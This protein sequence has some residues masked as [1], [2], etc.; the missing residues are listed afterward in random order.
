VQVLAGPLLALVW[1]VAA[2]TQP[3][4]ASVG[5]SCESWFRQ[6]WD[7]ARTVPP[8]RGI[9]VTWREEHWTVPPAEELEALRVA[10]AERPEHPERGLVE[11]YDRHRQGQPTVLRY[12]LWV[13]P[14]DGWRFNTD[15]G[16]G[17]EDVIRTPSSAWNLN[18]G[19]VSLFDAARIPRGA[20]AAAYGRV[21][22]PQLGLLFF[23]GLTYGD[24]SG[25]AVSRFA[26]EG[27][28]WHA[29]A[30]RPPPGQVGAHHALRFDGSWDQASATGRVELVTL[31]ASDHA[32][33]AVGTTWRSSG[34][35]VD[36]MTG[37]R[38][39]ARVE[40]RSPAGALER[41]LVLETINPI[42]KGGFAALVNPPLDGRSDAV[43][44]SMPGLRVQEHR[45][46]EILNYEAGRRPGLI[47]SRA[48][49]RYAGWLALAAMLAGCAVAWRHRHRAVA[50]R[51][52]HG[53][54]R[55][56]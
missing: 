55:H 8:V 37:V 35:T 56:G 9:G 50:R 44:G 4:A 16:H 49:L 5:S 20:D 46:G 51:L 11:Q 54:H 53:G 21:F 45:D 43:R 41:V 48:I 39:A 27:E 10:V 14:V 19:Q 13:G 38:H 26:C 29:I 2:A 31:V 3:V 34:W 24:V 28:R 6:E 22:R 23:G 47:A 32:P 1:S 42:P 40:I 17:F 30:E 36:A 52:V 7:R 12:T 33:S 25:L 15:P 18:P